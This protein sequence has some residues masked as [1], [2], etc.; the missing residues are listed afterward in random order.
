MF[1]TNKSILSLINDTP[2]ISLQNLIDH[3]KNIHLQAGRAIQAIVIG[4]VT[5]SQL[6]TTKGTKFLQISITDLNRTTTSLYCYGDALI[7]GLG[8]QRGH[9]AAFRAME[10]RSIQF[11]YKE[12]VQVHIFKY[13]AILLV[14]S[15][16]DFKECAFEEKRC[17]NCVPR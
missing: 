13:D 17:V 9:V 7:A 8:L 2:V 16:A 10:S 1:V 12:V 5:G 3:A 6:K 14:G 15:G 4:Y 11:K